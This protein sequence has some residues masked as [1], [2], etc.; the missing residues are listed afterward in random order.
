VNL[1]QRLKDSYLPDESCWFE[2]R[3]IGINTF[4]QF[5]SKISLFCQLSK[6]YTNHCLK[7]ITCTVLGDEF[8]ENDIKRISGKLL[9]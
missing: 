5:M 8:E 6:K 3:K 7:V 1:W 2:N 4:R 9:F